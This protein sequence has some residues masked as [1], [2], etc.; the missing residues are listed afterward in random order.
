MTT[1]ATNTLDQTRHAKIDDTD[2]ASF[3]TPERVRHIEL[4]GFVVL[5]YPRFCH[6]NRFKPF[7]WNY[8]SFLPR[9]P[10]I[11]S[12]NAAIPTSGQLTRPTRSISLLNQLC[13]SFFRRSLAM[14]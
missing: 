9:P 6:T 13:L 10:I 8:L 7:G 2:W 3:T 12:I 14:I 5:P 4:E 1:L 11:A